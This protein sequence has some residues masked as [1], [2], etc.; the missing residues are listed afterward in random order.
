[1]Y[2][3]TH[4]LRMMFDTFSSVTHDSG[5]LAEITSTLSRHGFGYLLAKFGLGS[6]GTTSGSEHASAP[7]RLRQTLEELGPTFIKL[8]QILATRSDLLEPEWIAELE[9]LQSDAPRLPFS[10]LQRSLEDA[11]GEPVATA[12]ASF[13][14]IPLAA[15]SMAQVHRA[16]LHYGQRVAVKIRRPGIRPRMEA[17]LR[18]LARLASMAE[19]ASPDLRH[20]Q[21]KA[22]VGQLANA[23]V[24]ELDFTIEA[25]N[26]DTLRADFANDERVVVPE[27]HWDFTSETVL[28]MDYIDGVPPTDRA[29]LQVEG[30]DTAQLAALGADVVLDMVLINGRFHADPHPGNLRCLPGNRLALLDLGLIGH[31]SPRRREE[32]ISFTQALI[33]SDS[34]GLTDVLLSWAGGPGTPDPEKIRSAAESLIA[35][36]G[37]QKLVLSAIVA[38]F[39]PMLRERG[40]SMPPDLILIFKALVTMDGVLTR[41]EP[42]FDL[43]DA[44]KRSSVRL[45]A[46]RLAPSHWQPLLQALA[47]ELAKVGNDAPR[48]VRSVA[49]KLTETATTQPHAYEQRNLSRAIWGGSLIIA[50]AIIL[51]KIL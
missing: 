48:L 40:L 10:A 11:L 3:F 19:Q 31:V 32:F 8:G 35:R 6:G 21:P 13:D 45:A 27:I 51:T 41:I 7:Q 46:A 38:D 26:A 34:G 22:V 42:G 50:A 33:T 49:R 2:D 17:D 28:V 16:V 18:I 5:R 20:F 39:M 43:S 4:Y 1:M 25:H 15:A 37:G 47:W 14:E 44:I 12:F 23:M 9:K 29:A 24:Q 36:H 30:I